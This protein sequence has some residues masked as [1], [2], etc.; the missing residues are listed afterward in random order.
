MAAN[1]PKRH[2]TDFTM[3]DLLAMARGQNEAMLRAS[4]AAPGVDP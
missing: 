3:D 4:E 2:G 1:M